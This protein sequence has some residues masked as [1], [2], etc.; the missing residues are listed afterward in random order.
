MSDGSLSFQ[1][2]GKCK[3][4]YSESSVR[5]NAAFRFDFSLRIGLCRKCCMVSLEEEKRKE[6]E[7][8]RG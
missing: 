8:G 5:L 1:D 2:N 6:K 3:L 4:L 7:E